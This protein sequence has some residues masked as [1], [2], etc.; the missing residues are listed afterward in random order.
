MDTEDLE[1][2]KDWME[3]VPFTR[4]NCLRNLT[5]EFSDAVCAA[6]VLKHYIP[7]LVD[8]NHYH[9]VSAKPQKKTQWDT[10]N[11][12]CFSKM[13]IAIPNDTI[14]KVINNSPGYIELILRNMKLKVE[15]FQRGDLVL[16]AMDDEA[17][18]DSKGGGKKG[19]KK[20][21]KHKKKHS[22]AGASLA[23]SDGS[24]GKADTE[25]T[26]SGPSGNHQDEI[27]SAL[28]LKDKIIDDYEEVV[29][30]FQVKIKK[31]EALM[32]LKEKRI[33]D[34]ERKCREN[35]IGMK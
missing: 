16:G 22:K 23:P 25:S 13:G 5:R 32:R 4:A 3:D 30:A 21:G 29:K 14:E 7:K 15:Q 10:L 11:K 18:G 28:T 26:S 19:G 1:V 2:L 6:E 31:M 27:V 35:G 34:L 17:G 9:P 12:K 20:G 33:E 24:A 8:L